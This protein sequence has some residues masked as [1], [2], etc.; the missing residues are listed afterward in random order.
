[1]KR[2][3]VFASLAAA[4]AMAAAQDCRIEYQRADNMWAAA[5]RPDGQLGAET[6]TLKPG[7]K[8]VFATDWKY[9]KRRND[10][11]NYYGSHVRIMRNVG[12]GDVGLVMHGLGGMEGSAASAAT[13]GVV[14][15]AISQL[16]AGQAVNDLRADLAE[17]QCAY[18]SARPGQTPATPSITSPTGLTARQSAP[19]QIV[20]QWQPVPQ[21]KEYRVYFSPPPSPTME[22]KPSVVGGNGS[23]FVIPIPPS[24][25]PG[26]AYHASIEAVGTNGTVS[27]RAAFPTVPVNIAGGP[28]GPTTGGPGA[29]P[30]SGATP[31]LAGQ[32]CPPGQ[33]VTGFGPTGSLICASPR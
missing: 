16:K 33:F 6:L 13:A 32:Q 14:G 19:N 29:S 10:G 26:T 28:G 4:A 2:M 18:S 17:V 7:Q 5:G 1:M 30:T 31:A 25:A 21:A 9:E 3:V 20:L 12:Q 22:G 27:A 8:K 23:H 15:R 24:V 11:T